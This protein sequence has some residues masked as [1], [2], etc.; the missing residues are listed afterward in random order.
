MVPAMVTDTSVPAPPSG[1][2]AEDYTLSTFVEVSEEPTPS[3]SEAS[4]LSGPAQPKDNDPATP[5]TP[6]PSVDLGPAPDEVPSIEGV[7]AGSPGAQPK[8]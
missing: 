2:F 8:N 7:G 1:A 6:L 5:P 3:E 4:S